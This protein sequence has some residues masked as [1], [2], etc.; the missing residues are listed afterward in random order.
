LN[1]VEPQAWLTATLTT[2]I[3]DH[4]QPRIDQLLPWNYKTKTADV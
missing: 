3:N 2:I 4:K 1:N